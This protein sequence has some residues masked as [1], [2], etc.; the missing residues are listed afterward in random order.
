[1]RFANVQVASAFFC[2]ERW[3]ADFSGRVLRDFFIWI[4]ARTYYSISN[5]IE[6]TLNTSEV[7]CKM[8]LAWRVWL[9]ALP[10]LPKK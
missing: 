1:M 10:P 7:A 8:K 4:F 2:P 6:L 5:S 3:T 9:A